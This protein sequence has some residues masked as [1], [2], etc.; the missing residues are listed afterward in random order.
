M[1]QLSTKYSLRLSLLISLIVVTACKHEFPEVPEETIGKLEDVDLSKTVFLGSSLFSGI[2]NGALT[3]DNASFSIPEILLDHLDESAEDNT[4]S[5]NVDTENGFNIFE[6]NQ[7]SGTI[8][9][10]QI[11]FPSF[12]TTA[13][14]R[15]AT[16]GSSFEYSNASSVISNYSF[17]RAQVLDFTESSRSVNSF[18]PGFFSGSN[19]SL[20]SRIASEQP[21]FFILNLGYE[22]LL[23]Y[24]INGGQGTSGVVDINNHQYSDILSPAVFEQKLQ[25]VADAL[26]ATNPDSKGALLTIPDFLKFPFFIK[27]NYDVT[28]YIID[29]TDLVVNV[30]NQSLIFNQRINQ[31]YANNPGIPFED[32]RPTLDFSDDIQFQWGILVED[33]RLDNLTLNGTTIPKVR[34]I[35]REELVFFSNE[36]FLDSSRGIFPTNALSGSQYLRLDKIQE[37]RS[38]IAAYNQA[39]QNVVASSNGRL[40]MIDIAAYFEELFQGLN[41]L[42]NQPAQGA[43]ID[44]VSFLPI[45]G[46]FGIFSADGLNLNARGNALMVNQI[47]KLLNASFNGNLKGIDPNTFRGTSIKLPD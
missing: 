45:T 28:P 12:D 9:Q 37:L 2:N 22:D 4:F 30:R 47:I 5:P 14:D 23:G 7:L 8:G 25:T 41:R 10:Y 46:E 26:L 24:A 40:I 15:K 43:I 1:I 3:K 34:H 17:P 39:I 35:Q 6:N 11:Y 44:G 18:I 38:Q 33:D 20:L 29:N 21:G 31:Y 36:S 42:L 27:V 13:F 32:R 16:N 19:G